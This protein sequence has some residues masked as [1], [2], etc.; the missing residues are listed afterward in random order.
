MGDV[1]EVLAIGV[2]VVGGPT[3]PTG[4]RGAT[5]PTGATGAQGAAGA[6][7]K[8]Y[9]ISMGGGIFTSGTLRVYD[10]SVKVGSY[11]FLQYNH[12]GS[13]GNAC[14]VETIGNGYFDVSGSTGKRFMYLVLTAYTP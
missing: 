4:P 8:S 9:L 3:G 2:Q 11:V 14:S 12:P 7:G 5:G 6:D 13:P 10:A 1:P